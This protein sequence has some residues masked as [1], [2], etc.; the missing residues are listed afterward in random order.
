MGHGLP[1]PRLL[2]TGRAR[3]GRGDAGAALRRRRPPAHP[4]GFQR[5]HAKLA[6]LPDVH[7]LHRPGRQVPT[8]GAGGVGL[9]PA[10]AHLPLHA[11]RG[12][13]PHV[14]GR[15]RRDAGGAAH[16]GGDERAGHRR[17]GASAGG[18]RDRSVH[19]P[20]VHQLPLQRIG[21]PVR[22]G[23]IHQRGQLLHSGTQGPL[24]GVANRRR[25]P[26]DRGSVAGA[27]SA[28]TKSPWRNCRP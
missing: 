27:H 22:A 16:R 7:L 18:W 12:G 28:R 4:W 2:R 9:R 23:G 11:Y 19:C 21:G 26:P 25:P 20:E 1:A 10:V 5:G 15:D 14:R 24:P 17:P 13:P 6:V 3:G 8:G